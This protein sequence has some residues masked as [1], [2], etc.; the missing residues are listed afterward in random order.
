MNVHNEI[1]AGEGSDC[2]DQTTTERPVI[3]C[4]TILSNFVEK[5]GLSERIDPN[6]CEDLLTFLNRIIQ[7]FS[8]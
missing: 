4:G 2:C 6:D 7:F 1:T 3:E 8:G 5:R